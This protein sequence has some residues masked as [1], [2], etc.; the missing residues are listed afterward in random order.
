[1]PE[2]NVS[3]PVSYAPVVQLALGVD[4]VRPSVTGI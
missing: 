2:I 1:M 3:V 4:W